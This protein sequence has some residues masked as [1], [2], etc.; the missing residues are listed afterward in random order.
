[1]RWRS[2][3]RAPQYR[4]VAVLIG[5]LTVLVFQIAAPDTTAGRVVTL[6]L[7][8]LTLA[9]III[10]SGVPGGLRMLARLGIFLILAAIVVGVVTGHFDRALTGAAGAAFSLAALPAVGYG[11]VAMMRTSGVS[12][13]VVSGALTA[14]LL[15]GLL[16]ASVIGIL[17]A[18]ASNGYFAGG[19][20]GTTSDHVYF[21]FT[22]LTTTGYGDLTPDTRPGRSI[23]VVEM[24]LGQLYLVTVVGV[25]VAN[26]ANPRRE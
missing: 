5:T 14:Y 7:Q 17:A 16:F 26:L 12:I 18:G 4:F 25:L 10:T 11:V 2:K 19:Q 8:G 15:A 24:L 13:Q 6:G 21:S 23:A 3:D 22:T 20:K 1:V 9:T